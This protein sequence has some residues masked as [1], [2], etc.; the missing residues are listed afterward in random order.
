MTVALVVE[1]MFLSACNI[2]CGWILSISFVIF[3]L[4]YIPYT[5]LL[6]NFDEN[7]KIIDKQRE[8]RVFDIPN[9]PLQI[10]CYWIYGACWFYWQVNISIF[11]SQLKFNSKLFFFNAIFFCFST[12]G[13]SWIFLLHASSRMYGRVGTRNPVRNGNVQY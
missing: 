7:I 10:V 11:Q 9:K 4:T 5:I 1:L 3:H 2:A 12:A 8:I 13:R 6:Q